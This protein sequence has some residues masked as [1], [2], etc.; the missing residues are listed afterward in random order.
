MF[1]LPPPLAPGD[2]VAVVAPSG[3]FDAA[4]VWRGLGWIRG[5]YRVRASWGMFSR[6][7]YLA[8]TDARRAAELAAAMADPEVKAILCARGGYGAMRILESLPWERFRARPK[9]IAGFSDVTALHARA[10]AIGVA[11][12]HGPN[13]SG[14][15]RA[16]T[17]WVRYRWLMALEHPRAPHA[18]EGLRVVRAGRAE[19]PIVGGN[20]ALLHAMSAAGG[21]HV[22]DGAVLAIEDVTEKP[23][24]IDRMLT[25][26]TLGGHTR[27][28]AGVILGG[29]TE[30]DPGKDGVTWESVVEGWARALGVPVVADAPF[31]H[32]DRNEAFVL[33]ATVR[34]DGD[35]VELNPD[36]RRTADG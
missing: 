17:P 4:E 11:S 16:T 28:L 33:G 31:G 7:G 30:C 34:I 8:G 23:Y 3:P 1:V 25:A 10:C 15:G 6:Y 13:V 35:R 19:G 2:L 27:K 20:L 12:V 29:F 24:R 26:L 32:L 14:L 18:W 36:G 22:P 5:R 21:V 9:W